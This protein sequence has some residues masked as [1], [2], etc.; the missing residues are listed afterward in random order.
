MWAKRWRSGFGRLVA[1]QA[2]LRCE[3]VVLVIQ[4][5]NQRWATRWKDRQIGCERQ[6]WKFQSASSMDSR[7]TCFCG[8]LATNLPIAYSST[9]TDWATVKAGILKCAGL[10]KP[11]KR[12][13]WEHIVRSKSSA[14]KT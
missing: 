13:Y 8:R 10:G 14:R 1:K 11:L 4:Q 6:D 3:R 2:W 9:R 7:K 5:G 12:L